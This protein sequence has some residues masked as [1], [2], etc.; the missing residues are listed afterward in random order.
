MKYRKNKSGDDLSILGFGCMRLPTRAGI[1]DFNAA[2]ATLMYAYENGV[3]YFDTAYIYHAGQ[4]EGF[5]GRALAEV[6]DKVNIATKLPPYLVKRPA[7]IEKI[8]NTQMKR[9]GTEYIDYYLM[10]AVKDLSTWEKL[11]EHG[12]IDWIADKKAK[13]IIKN[14]GFSFHGVYD[15]F[16]KLLDAY[17]WDFVQIQYNYL[18]EYNQAGVAGLDYASKKGLP[19]IIMEPLLGGR[20]AG[21][22]PEAAQKVLDEFP[23]EWSNAEWAL[24]WLWN[25]PR[26][27][28]VLSG[29]GDMAQVEENVRIAGEAM[30]G[31]LSEDELTAIEDVKLELKR[32]NK[33]P[34]TG[35]RYCMPCP[36]NV[37][38]PG[39]FKDYNNLDIEPNKVMAKLKHIGFK[40]GLTGGAD[41]GA[42]MCIKCG[43]CKPQCPQNIDIPEQLDN[44]AR[45]MEGILYKMISGIKKL[46]KK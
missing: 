30:P 11:I 10:H 23:N 43:K 16:I 5:V 40:S 6:R 24:R 8:F 4:S 22:H 7:D 37:D 12:I 42:H 3:N 19:V 20:L 1:I 44:V 26:V 13:G 18:D 36:N 35:C 28:V 39:C 31:G 9:L 33:V 17:E 41:T 38:I 25:D 27:T 46:G 14:I 29:M 15:E 45:E 32:R 2:K 34:C 21:A